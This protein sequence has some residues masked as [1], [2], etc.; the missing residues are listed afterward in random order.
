MME[1]VSVALE[2]PLSV[3]IYIFCQVCA[4][5]RF[6]ILNPTDFHGSSWLRIYEGMTKITQQPES[7]IM[8]F[9]LFLCLHF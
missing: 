2:V 1:N 9:L 6:S 4:L 7:S 8:K 5:K 3:Y